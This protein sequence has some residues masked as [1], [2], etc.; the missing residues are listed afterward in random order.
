MAN[1]APQFKVLC[2]DETQLRLESQRKALGFH[3]NNNLASVYLT[4]LS[5][6]PPEKVW[7]VLS[8]VSRYKSKLKSPA[9]SVP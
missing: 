9:K 4:A 2:S 8:L 6:V 7:E 3:T 1:E 5:E